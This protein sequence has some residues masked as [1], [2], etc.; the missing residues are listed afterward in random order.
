MDRFFRHKKDSFSFGNVNVQSI[1]AIG[2]KLERDYLRFF[3]GLYKLYKKG[4]RKNELNY[5]IGKIRRAITTI[6]NIAMFGSISKKDADKLLAEIN[7]INESKEVFIEEIK[8]T[9]ALKDRVEKV[10]DETGISSQDLNITDSVIKES[11]AIAQKTPREPLSKTMPR[12]HQLASE[13]LR[14]VKGAAFG[15]FSQLFD[16]ATGVFKDV[17]GIIKGRREA[18]IEKSIKNLQPSGYVGDSS[19]LTTAGVLSGTGAGISGAVDIARDNDVIVASLFNFFNKTAYKAKWTKELLHKVSETGTTQTGGLGSLG[20]KLG[21]VAIATA[22]TA[23]KISTLIDTIKEFK[24]VREEAGES[25]KKLEIKEDLSRDKYIRTKISQIDEMKI[26][27]EEKRRK[28]VALFKAEGADWLKSKEAYE[29]G[30][31]TPEEKLYKNW[32]SGVTAMSSEF[33]ETP[34]PRTIKP[35]TKDIDRSSISPQPAL[36][37]NVIESKNADK[38]YDA[39]NELSESVRK[40]KE[41]PNIRIPNTGVY[42]SADPLI[43]LHA[44]GNLTLG[45]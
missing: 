21:G 33:L 14:G 11:L 5:I 44:A 42:D 26:S 39:I 12:T 41:L 20:L 3:N 31:T 27:D 40:D 13:I 2:R 25:V 30:L 45:E 8:N 24:Q 4:E 15:P 28:K 35:A 23:D 32:R 7:E 29:E 37:S 19:N 1:I 36:R 17:R 22:F 6:N 10:T 16:V 38:L 9:K 34:K 43:N 18:S